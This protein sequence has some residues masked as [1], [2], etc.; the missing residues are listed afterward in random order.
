VV[1]K[2]CEKSFVTVL[3]DKLSTRTNSTFR[4]Y[5]SLI[6]LINLNTSVMMDYMATLLV[7]WIFT[8]VVSLI[9]NI[10]ILIDFYDYGL[11]TLSILGAR[12]LVTILQMLLV[13]VIAERKVNKK[14]SFPLHI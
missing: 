5:Y 3:C 10:Y 4:N 8:S 1:L 14:V 2:A 9:F 12:T 13:L 7:M 6:N 11:C